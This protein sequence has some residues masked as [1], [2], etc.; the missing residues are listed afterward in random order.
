MMEQKQKVF[1]T[2]VGDYFNSADD[3]KFYVLKGQVRE[4]PDEISPII[5]DALE[6]GLLREATESEMEAYHR[7]QE[8]ELAIRNG[9]VKPGKDS[10]ETESN[11]NAYREKLAKVQAETKTVAPKPEKKPESPKKEADPFS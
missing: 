10:K 5:E 1:V 4:L 7:G 6:Q 3:L 8:I 9:R 11:F 2:C